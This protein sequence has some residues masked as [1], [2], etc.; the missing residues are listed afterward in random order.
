MSKPS[1]HV[2]YI[3]TED[4]PATAAGLAV[5]YE[6]PV[7]EVE[8]YAAFYCKD[9][10]F[11]FR[12]GSG[13]PIS[14]LAQWHVSLMYFGEA[15]VNDIFDR[16]QPTGPCKITGMELFAQEAPAGSDVVV[17]LVDGAGASL[18]RSI[19]LPDGQKVVRTTFGALNV[20]ANASVR[21]KIIGTGDSVKGAW[22]HLRLH[23]S[24]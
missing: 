9:G 1:A 23:V 12:A 4:L 2:L 8:K 5:L 20:A 11:Y 7:A 14:F 6:V 19:L 10:V 17:E 15:V 18:G 21:A 16:F 3:G 24:I 22:L 13:G